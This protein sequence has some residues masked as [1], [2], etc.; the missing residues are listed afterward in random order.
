MTDIQ[1]LGVIFV[2]VLVG[3]ICQNFKLLRIQKRLRQLQE[4]Q[5]Q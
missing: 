5:N 2:I 1:I 4:K 3:F